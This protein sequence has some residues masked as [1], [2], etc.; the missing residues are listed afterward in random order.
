VAIA[1]LEWSAAGEKILLSTRHAI[2][3]WQV[4]CVRLGIREHF[5][6]GTG[7]WQAVGGAGYRQLVADVINLCAATGVYVVIDLHR[8][9]APEQKHADFWTEF[10]T[11]YKDHPAVLFELFNEPH[12]ISWEVW[13]NGGFVSTAKK[14][15]T[16]AIAENT[17]K[18]RGFE[19]IGMQAMIKAVRDTGAKNIVIAGGLDWAYDLSGILEGY[20]L[21]DLGGNGLVYSTHVYVWKSGWQKSFLDAAEKYPLLVSECGAMVEPPSFIPPERHEDPYV[22]VPDFLGVI[23]KHKLNWTARCFHPTSSTCL[24]S[25]WDYTPTPYWGTMAKDAIAGKQFETKRLR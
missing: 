16:D 9:R 4:N 6:A 18:L 14:T 20:A 3:E 19:S 7:P 21:D 24:I 17:D 22:W 23:Q 12:D 11:L 8:F 13:R 25:D 2:D 5:W 15:D 1:S 10:A